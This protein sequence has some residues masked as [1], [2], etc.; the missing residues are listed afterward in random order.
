MPVP[1]SL[2]G[3]TIPVVGAPM[4]LVSGPDLVIAQC[5]AGVVGSF[6]SLNARP[7]SA[8][9]D[10]IAQIRDGLARFEAAHPGRRAAPFAVNLIVNKANARLSHDTE[11]C[12]RAK[13]PI[14]ITS[15]QAPG[16]IVPAA[17]AYGGLVFH[18]VTTV[19]HAEKAAEAGVDGIVLVCAGA[20]GHA[21][22][23]SPF[24]LL[25]EVRRV[26]P[27]TILLAGAISTGR[28]I[29]AARALGADLAYLGT[30]FIATRESLASDAYKR[31]IVEAAAKDVVYTPEFTGVAGNYLLPSILAAGLDPA[32]LALPGASKEYRSREKSGVS[33]WRD[34][35]S[36]GQGVGSIEDVPTVAAL[37]DR[38]AAEFAAAR[39][40][41]C[42]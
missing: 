18:D 15:L 40:D 39:S 19:R 6:P 16:E 14:I 36:A 38:L 20:G 27:G 30:R 42:G 22:A 11:A 26:F 33:A 23:M 32:T 10:W 3:L 2:A 34:I 12:L 8:L 9:A 7:E 4:F 41:V 1:A 28:G 37:V 21:G 5:S 24:A 17:H 31:M 35:W 29:L 13:V 25:P